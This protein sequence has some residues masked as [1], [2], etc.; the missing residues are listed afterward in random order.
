ML[1]VALHHKLVD[2]FVN[3]GI[4]RVHTAGNV[5]IEQ[6]VK[7]EC[8]A[9]HLRIIGLVYIPFHHFVFKLLVISLHCG[10]ES[11]PIELEAHLLLNKLDS[12]LN[13]VNRI[14]L[15]ILA[16]VAE[17]YIY[18]MSRNIKPSVDKARIDYRTVARHI[19]GQRTFA[20]HW[21][22]VVNRNASLSRRQGANICGNAVAFRNVKVVRRYLLVNH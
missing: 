9:R 3:L 14:L 8:S 18:R 17:R 10:K 21:I 11:V 5:E 22:V 6:S 13:L 2:L 16:V 12:R 4:K 19:T 20:E 15:N 1:L 7:P